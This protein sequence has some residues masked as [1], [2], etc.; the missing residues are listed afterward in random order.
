MI[1]LKDVARV[2]LDHFE[3]RAIA[4]Y[5]GN[6][7]I[8]MAVRRE[9]GSNVIEIKEQMLKVVNALNEDVLRPAGMQLILISDDVRY[10]S[11]SIRNVWQNLVIG[12][13]LAT[14]VMYLFLRSE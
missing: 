11:D 1:R 10:V 9:A 6:S 7:H 5:N 13:L 14:A 4:T 3:K 12:A 8:M 2:A